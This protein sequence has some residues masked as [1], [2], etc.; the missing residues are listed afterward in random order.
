ML[1]GDRSPQRRQVDGEVLFLNQARRRGTELVGV[2]SA[3]YLGH[4]PQDI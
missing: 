3:V 2:N 4:V 1:T